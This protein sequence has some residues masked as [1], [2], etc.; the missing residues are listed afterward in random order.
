MR[1]L[2]MAVLILVGALDRDFQEA[3][4]AMA[5]AVPGSKLVVIDG[6]G[7]SPQFE[8]PQLWF[9]ALDSFLRSVPAIA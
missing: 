7:H 3:A 6:A 2:P 5:A 8:Q 4:H 9:A 1:T